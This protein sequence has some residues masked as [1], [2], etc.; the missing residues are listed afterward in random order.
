MLLFQ[1]IFPALSVCQEFC[2][3]LLRGS[4]PKTGPVRFGSENQFPLNFAY[5]YNY[6]SQKVIETALV[7]E[8]ISN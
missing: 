6:L 4:L 2:I 8:N 7:F 5:E 1:D 3:L